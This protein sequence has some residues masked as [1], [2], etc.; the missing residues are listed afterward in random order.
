MPDLFRVGLFVAGVAILVPACSE[1]PKL[2]LKSAAVTGPSAA[3]LVP[4]FKMGGKSTDVQRQAKEQEIKGKIVEWS[5]LKVY[6]VGKHGEA[7]YKIQTSSTD[8]ALS[9]FVHTCPGDDAT[10][11]A[12]VALKTGDRIDVKGLVDDVT[13][14]RSV[15]IDPALVSVH[16]GGAQPASSA[17]PTPTPAASNSATAPSAPTTPDVTISKVVVKLKNG[18]GSHKGKYVGV[19]FQAKAIVKPEKG[20]LV[21]VKASCKV[22]DDTMVDTSRALGLGLDKV[23]A[24]ESKKGDVSFWVLQPL[25]K[26]PTS[27]TLTFGTEVGLGD[28][29]RNLGAYCFTAP[30]AVVSGVCPP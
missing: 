29:E 11:A 22:G 26:A 14:L 6:E 28:P 21:A 10:K 25:E 1:K 5:G 16:V 18:F 19:E 24:G 27:C 13:V 17:P 8:D 20:A 7:C 15:D 23:G 4:I 12:I 2:D 30:N 3:E 9:T